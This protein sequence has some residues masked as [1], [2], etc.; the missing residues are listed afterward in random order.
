MKQEKSAAYAVIH[1]SQVRSGEEVAKAPLV[2]C[3]PSYAPDAK[4]KRI[5]QVIRIICIL[6]API[7]NTNDS[8]SCQ[9]IM[10]AKV[11]HFTV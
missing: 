1:P 6:K 3:D 4:K 5:G 7:P 2:I 10:T 8:A 9:I 11:I